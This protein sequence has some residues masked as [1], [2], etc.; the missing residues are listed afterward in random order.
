MRFVLTAAAALL[1]ACG[2]P[3]DLP[4]VNTNLIAATDD[5][6]TPSIDT[7]VVSQ[8]IIWNFPGN[9]QNTHNVTWLSGPALNGVTSND[10]APGAPNYAQ[11]FGTVG[12]YTY[13]CTHHQSEGMTGTLVVCPAS[14]T[15]AGAF[16]C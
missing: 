15:T 1:V 10:R 11:F 12:T 9:N 2:S 5:Q 7:V 6:F 4:H 8:D 3:S 16:A 13:A 14:N